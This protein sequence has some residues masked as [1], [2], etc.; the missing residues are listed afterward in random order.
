LKKRY[1][2]ALITL[3]S[4]CVISGILGVFSAIALS[5]LSL[6][7]TLLTIL[8]QSKLKKTENILILGIDAT[9]NAKRSD[10]IMVASLDIERNRLGLI[11][12]PRDTRVDIPGYGVNKINHAY[13]Y[14]GVRLVQKSISKFL[15][16]PINYFVRVDLAGIKHFVDTIGGVEVSVKDDM[17]YVDKAGEL[18][19]DIPKGEQVLSGEESVG[20]LRYRKDRGD[21]GRINRQQE[22]IYSVAR[23]VINQGL[24]LKAPLL[25]KDLSNHIYTNLSVGKMVNLALEMRR[26]LLAG[27]VNM[28]TLPGSVV[29]IDNVSYW[30]PDLIASSKLI[31]KILHGFDIAESELQYDPVIIQKTTPVVRKKAV[32]S[33]PKTVTPVKREKKALP[34]RRRVTL[35][36]VNQVIDNL[37]LPETGQ[38]LP[39]GVTLT[40]EVLNGNGVNRAA[41]ALASYLKNRGI[42]VPRF[43]MAG[44]TDYKETLIVDWKSKTEEAIALAR[45]LNIKPSNIVSY[46]RPDKPL[47]ITI[48]LGKD[49][50]GVKN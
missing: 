41:R 15:Q 14:G 39:P 9:T 48:V 11:S 40:V 46:N 42:K 22:F 1:K 28:K 25:I 23:R 24:L 12:I 17:Y 31:D 6:I 29:L 5:R 4:T 49:W 2:F 35:K 33:L 18:Y 34:K 16:I 44:H 21:I 37:E 27:N 47:D 7:D 26:S 36:E 43:A 32:V 38:L 3:L 10:T 45:S 19:I 13:A 20:Y 50:Q 30:K 8:P